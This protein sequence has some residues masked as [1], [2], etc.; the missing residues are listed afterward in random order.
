M[1]TNRFWNFD[2]G[3]TSNTTEMV[4]SH[5][6]VSAQP[7]SYCPTLTVSGPLGIGAATSCIVVTNAAPEPA[8]VVWPT[9]GAAHLTVFY[10]TNLSRFATN[11]SWS[12]GDGTTTNSSVPVTV[13]VMS[14]IFGPFFCGWVCPTGALFEKGR[15]VAEMEKRR[16]FLPYLTLM[17]EEHE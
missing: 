1:I 3:S 6:Y 9:N 4:V 14:M 5:T 8:F 11:Y 10:F 17:R 15:S 16:S 7:Y 13:M 12:F 2:D